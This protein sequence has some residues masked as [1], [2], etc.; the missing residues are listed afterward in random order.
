MQPAVA[1][2]AATEEQD[3]GGV[4]AQTVAVFYAVRV[5]LREW[6]TEALAP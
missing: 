5:K 6:V 2:K 3:V 4:H 1:R